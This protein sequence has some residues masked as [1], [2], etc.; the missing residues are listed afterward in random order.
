MN[1]KERRKQQK[2]EKRAQRTNPAVRGLLQKARTN[3]EAGNLDEAEKD[4]REV[5]R[6][7]SLDAEAFHM[8]ALIAY[9]NGRLEE[10]GDMIL[11]AITRDDKDVASSERPS[12]FIMPPQLAWIATSLS[13][14]VIASRIISPASSSRPFR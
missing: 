13:S 9:R 11:E 12:K 7:D 2:Q 10:A 4:F 14:R 6:L 3:F 5:S 8:R 1:R